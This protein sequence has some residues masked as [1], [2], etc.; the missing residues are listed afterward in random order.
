MAGLI[1]TRRPHSKAI[2]AGE[3]VVF[4]HTAGAPR[5]FAQADPEHAH[6]LS[7][8]GCPSMREGSV[9]SEGDTE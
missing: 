2:P 8:A 5:T 4:L 9:S 1:F 6:G 3:T 7:L